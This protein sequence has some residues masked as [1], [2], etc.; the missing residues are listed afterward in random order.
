MTATTPDFQHSQLLQTI[1]AEPL[2]SNND[3]RESADSE[4]SILVALSPAPTSAPKLW[5][6]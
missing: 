6:S 1:C 2:S 3:E 4:P 5:K